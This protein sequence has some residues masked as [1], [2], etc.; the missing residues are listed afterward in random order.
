MGT[1][2]A[3]KRIPERGQYGN[4]RGKERQLRRRNNRAQTFR[5]QQATEEV[6]RHQQDLDDLM[7][8][9]AAN[10]VMGQA[11]GARIMAEI[12]A[13]HRQNMAEIDLKA[14]QM[15]SEDERVEELTNGVVAETQP[16]L[17]KKLKIER[18]K[19]KKES[20]PKFQF[21]ETTARMMMK[22]GYNI[23]YVIEFTGVGYDDLKE[24]PID[25]EGYAIVPLD[26]EE[27]EEEDARDS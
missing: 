20:E 7:A 4:T 11:E 18:R 3:G 5:N 16:L 15:E 14:D 8:Q 23:Q 25:D 27:D 1:N 17:P 26:Y 12:K 6:K 2:K 21:A 10:P 9:Q 19:L 13:R 24:F 22:A